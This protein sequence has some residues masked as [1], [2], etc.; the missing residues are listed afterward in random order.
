MSQLMQV[1]DRKSKTLSNGSLLS[2]VK[3]SLIVSDTS[4]VFHGSSVEFANKDLVIFAERIRFSKKFLVEPHTTLSHFKHFFSCSLKVLNHCF[5]TV[6]PHQR[7]SLNSF[8]LVVIW[9]RH[10]SVEIR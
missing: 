10:Y 7:Q 1:S 8:F 4:H 2:T 3:I 6:Y 9:S 5:T